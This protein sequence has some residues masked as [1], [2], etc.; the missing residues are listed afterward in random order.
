[1]S[2]PKIPHLNVITMESINDFKIL[3]KNLLNEG[4][5]Q[6]PIMIDLEKFEAGQTHKF[7]D[8][9]G[10]FL[11]N[12]GICTRWPY[13]IYIRS[14][15]LTTHPLF[16]IVEDISQTASH[17]RL[18]YDKKLMTKELQILQR[19]HLTNR[20]I[21]NLFPCDKQLEI[22]SAMQ[23]NQEIIRETRRLHFYDTIIN[24]ISSMRQKS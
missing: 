1:M 15:T 11:E 6:C 7:L 24:K 20:Q 8:L 19:I 22:Q 23:S 5:G 18:D 12:A 17:F 2:M 16:E 10:K 4:A 13:P 9:L 3:P 21:H 14:L